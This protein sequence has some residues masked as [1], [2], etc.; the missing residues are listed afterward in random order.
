VRKPKDT[1]GDGLSDAYED[2]IGTDKTKKD[3]DGD[4]MSDAAELKVKTNPLTWDTDGDGFNDDYEVKSGTSPLKVDTDGDGLTDDGVEVGY[5]TNPLDK[6]E[7][8]DIV[9]ATAEAAEMVAKPTGKDT[10]GDG[11]SDEFELKYGLDPRR[12]DTDDDGLG[13]K[14]EVLR[15]TDPTQKATDSSGDWSDLGDVMRGKKIDDTNA[16]IPGQYKGSG[17][18]ADASDG[19]DRD[20]DVAAFISDDEA[21]RLAAVAPPSG[22][23]EIPDAGISDPEVAETPTYVAEASAAEPP[24]DG[25]V[26]SDVDS[27]TSSSF[28][29]S[30]SVASDESTFTQDEP[31]A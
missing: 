22:E 20:G 27:L 8:V 4:G 18:R 25:G 31:I 13:D 30:T 28:D 1:D 7:K 17:A 19:T 3:T 26:M 29:P 16:V 6:K 15:G 2:K 11:L 24:A 5:G 9:T 23:V 10:D 21:N 12:V 14:V